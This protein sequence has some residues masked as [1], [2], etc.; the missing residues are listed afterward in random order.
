MIPVQPNP[1][2]LLETIKKILKDIEN[3]RV[4]G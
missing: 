3:G 1:I 4:Q 2:E